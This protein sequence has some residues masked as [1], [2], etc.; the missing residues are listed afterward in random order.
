MLFTVCNAYRALVR[1][2]ALNLLVILS[3]GIGVGGG[4]TVF[5]WVEHLVR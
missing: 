3:V 4:T 5:G 2:P 1:A